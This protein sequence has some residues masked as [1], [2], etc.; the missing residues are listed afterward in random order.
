MYKKVYN[1]IEISN[2]ENN[3]D[4]DHKDFLISLI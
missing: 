1:E 2:C 4:G 3:I